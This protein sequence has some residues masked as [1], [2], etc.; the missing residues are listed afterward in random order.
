M[1]SQKAWH[2]IC[3]DLSLYFGCRLRGSTQLITP[4]HSLRFLEDISKSVD[5]HDYF[6]KIQGFFVLPD[7]KYKNVTDYEKFISTNSMLSDPFPSRDVGTRK[8]EGAYP[9]L[10]SWFLADQLT[11]SQPGGQIMPPHYYAP[12]IFRPSDISVLYTTSSKSPFSS[13]SDPLVLLAPNLT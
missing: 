2:E 5:N 12:Q 4:L 11:L 1:T 9:P 3:L 10:Q 13:C 8:A 6:R 7:L